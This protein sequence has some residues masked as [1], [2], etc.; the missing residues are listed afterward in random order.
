MT[1]KPGVNIRSTGVTRAAGRCLL[2]AVVLLLAA[3]MIMARVPAAHAAA[4]WSPPENLSPGEMFPFH[5]SPQIAVDSGGSSHVVWVAN[6]GSGEIYYS[7]NAGGAW[8]EPLNLSANSDENWNPQIAVG[9]DDHPHAAWEGYDGS[10]WQIFYS[11]DPGTGW[12]APVLISTTSNYSYNP[13]IAL[14]SGDNPHAVWTGY[15]QGDSASNV[16]YAANP[17]TG[18]EVPLILS[19]VPIIEDGSVF[20]EDPQIAVGPDGRP[21]AVWGGNDGLGEQVFYSTDPGTG[22]EAP[23][24]IST[25]I[26]S[27]VLAPQTGRETEDPQ[28][29][30]DSGGYAHVVW[31]G[32]DA[33]GIDRIWYSTDAEYTVTVAVEGGGGSATPVTQQVAHGGTVTIDITPEDGYRIGG[34]SDTGAPAPVADPYV[35]TDVRQD[36][37]VVVTFIPILADWYLAEGCTGEG[38]ET[39][40]LVQNPNGSTASVDL[41]LMTESGPLRPP[42][43]QGVSVPSGSRVSFNLGDYVTTYDVSAMVTSQGGDVICERAMYGGDGAWG[44]CSIGATAP[45]PVWYLAEGC[46]EGGMETWVLVQNPGDAPVLVD[47]TYMTPTGAV[48]GPQDFAVPARTRVSFPVAE[49]V[50]DYQVSTMVT[51]QG[52]DVICERAMYGGG[53]T[54]AHVSIGHAPQ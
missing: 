32:D 43:L 34:I 17:G 22:W 31:G 2:L 29:A 5:E 41:T 12:E 38:F 21:H 50:I 30:L 9:P 24:L 48:P 18:W 39:W 23:A 11:T 51:S 36:H 54:W 42:Q 44:T 40:V 27:A 49:H 52:G 16:F 14:D 46:T 53:R 4:V 7:T 15:D 47:L 6:S 35:I 19:T 1:P 20:N 13:K 3:A 45:A 33:K 8:S 26:S 28:I 25:S 10:E 37:D